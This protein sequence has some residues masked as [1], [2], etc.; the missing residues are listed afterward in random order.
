MGSGCKAWHKSSTALRPTAIWRPS[1]TTSLWIVRSYVQEIRAHCRIL[2]EHPL[3]GT[4]RDELVDSILLLPFRRR[5]NILYR[6]SG[7]DIRIL[8]VL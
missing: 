8:R 6:V 5:M 3:I 2:L 1:P 4:A 7:F